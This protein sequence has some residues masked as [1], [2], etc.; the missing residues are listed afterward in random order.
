MPCIKS[1]LFTA[2]HLTTT[3]FSTSHTTFDI[4]NSPP[5]SHAAPP[6][7]A[8]AF[9]NELKT[10]PESSINAALRANLPQLYKEGMFECDSS[11]LEAVHRTN[12]PLATQ[13]LMAARYE[14]LRRQAGPL[15]LNNTTTS[16]TPTVVGGTSS[17]TQAPPAPPT[18]SS[19]NAVIIPIVLSSTNAAGSVQA[20]TIPVL[21]SA[22]TSVPLTLTSTNAAGSPVF[23]T[24]NVPAVL[25][26]DS[27]GQIVTT[28]PVPTLNS[29]GDIVLTTTN[30]QGST[31]VTT[32]TPSGGVVSSEVLITTTL[33]NGAKST[34]TSF[35]IVPAAATESANPKL[36]GSGTRER[37]RLG[38]IGVL[39]FGV[40][41]GGLLL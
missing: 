36:Q 13:L 17:T 30:A 25:V 34:Y 14:L 22:S 2:L 29:N 41:L 12:A 20:T 6:E 3:F 31:F 39:M 19:N 28:A 24:T 37:P 5:L 11:A 9:R 7:R 1:V 38:L 35:A 10:L 21:A 23:V 33:P 40:L 26:T 15:G 8:V 32:I 18:T 4:N 27:A 16:T